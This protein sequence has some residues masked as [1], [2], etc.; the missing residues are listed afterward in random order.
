M[1]SVP[2]TCYNAAHLRIAKFRSRLSQRVEHR[3]EIE[4]GSANNLEYLGGRGLLFE[5]LVA[6]GGALSELAPQLGNDLLG[7]S[8]VAARPHVHR[9]TFCGPRYGSSIC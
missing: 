8:R 7:I 1:R 6:L 4:P 5:R 2:P 3:L 9:Q